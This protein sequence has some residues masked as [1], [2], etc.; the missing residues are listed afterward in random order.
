M[1]KLS[2]CIGHDPRIDETARRIVNR[3]DLVVFCFRGAFM[4]TC[5]A[6]IEHIAESNATLVAN[7]HPENIQKTL[8]R[9]NRRILQSENPKLLVLQAT[10]R[11][12]EDTVLD[13]LDWACELV[14][15]ERRISILVEKGISHSLT[16][17]R[18]PNPGGYEELMNELARRNLHT[19]DTRETPPSR[20]LLESVAYHFGE[21]EE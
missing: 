4:N 8:Q 13:A 2:D 15:K 6:T 16:W 7:E 10:K 21:P 11:V 1:N 14:G 12:L 20:V 18:K 5:N 19:I 3:I 17:V 9:T